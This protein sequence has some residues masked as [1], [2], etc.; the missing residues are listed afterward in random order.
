MAFSFLIRSRLLNLAS[1]EEC[2][3]A[4]AP[5][6]IFNGLCH[7]YARVCVR[8]ARAY[9]PEEVTGTWGCKCKP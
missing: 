6:M 1:R 4:I 3:A 8:P 2:A 5:V 7:A 9:V